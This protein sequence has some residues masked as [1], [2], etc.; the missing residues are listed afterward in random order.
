VAA[1]EGRAISVLLGNGDGT[2][3]GA[4]NYA[5]P[6][7]AFS[8]AL[9]DFNGDGNPD[10]AV[11]IHRE[12][13]PTIRGVAILPGNG[14]GTFA[15]PTIIPLTH[16]GVVTAVDFNGDGN[17]DLMVSSFHDPS[18]TI[19]LGD[20]HG[21]FKPYHS[22]T[23]QGRAL[24]IGDFNGDGKPGCGV[25]RQWLGRDFAGKWKARSGS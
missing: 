17:L 2:F 24:V 1:K 6:A 15:P 7:H 23:S 18:F 3:Q 13:S 20:G 21:G 5:L 19:L 10:L 4:R 14:D 11:S 8:V 16:H 22:H 25:G 9:G 12:K